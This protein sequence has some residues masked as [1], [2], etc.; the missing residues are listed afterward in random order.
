MPNKSGR[1]EKADVIPEQQPLH[2]LGA[3]IGII[4]DRLPLDVRRRIFTALDPAISLRQIIKLRR[5]KRRD[6]IEHHLIHLQL[7]RLTQSIL[8]GLLGLDRAGADQ[9][10]QLH[11]D[12]VFLQQADRLIDLRLRDSLLD[13]TQDLIIERLDTKIDIMTT[14]SPQHPR[15]LFRD[16][17]DSRLATPNNIMPFQCLT[18]QS[19]ALGGD[20]EIIIHKS[21]RLIALGRQLVNLLDHILR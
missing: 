21:D 19:Q 1:K 9:D 6:D 14:I 11:R 16:R 5:R 20:N 17:V 13:I 15:D 7:F 18:D 12:I 8:N 10:I 4:E 3:Q 2:L